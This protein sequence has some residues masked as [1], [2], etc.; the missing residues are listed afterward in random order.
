MLLSIYQQG[1]DSVSVSALCAVVIALLKYHDRL[2]DRKLLN[3]IDALKDMPQWHKDV[4]MI[5]MQLVKSCDT[6][7]VSRKMRDELLPEMMKLR[8]DLS[9]KIKDNMGAMDIS[10][11]DENPEWQEILENSGIADKMKEL[12]EMQE[13]GSDVF[14]STFAQLKSYPFFAKV[15]NWFLPFYV[16]HSEVVS[17]LGE[18]AKKVVAVKC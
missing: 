11:F 14:M 4:K 7:R 3:Q 17:A 15:A 12:T 9:Q 6:E 8:P 1:D 5:Y 16:E 10:T 13:E 18:N 2:T